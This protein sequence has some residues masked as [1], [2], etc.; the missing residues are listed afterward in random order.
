MPK[1]GLTL[2][3]MFIA[4]VVLPVMYRW[5]QYSSHGTPFVTYL[6]HYPWQYTLLSTLMMIIVVYRHRENISRL[7]GGSEARIGDKG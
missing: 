3:L 1:V 6:F 2:L 4:V 7:K 5:V